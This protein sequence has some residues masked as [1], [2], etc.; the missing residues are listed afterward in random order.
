MKVYCT[1]NSDDGDSD[2][3]VNSASDGSIFTRVLRSD[4]P[5]LFR[6]DTATACLARLHDL[7]S[8]GLHVPEAAIAALTSEA[9]IEADFAEAER[10]W[11]Q[12]GRSVADPQSATRERLSRAFD[13]LLG[14]VVAV[15][16]VGTIAL[17]RYMTN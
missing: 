12:V 2:V 13:L 7:R 17:I 10:G 5:H 3:F 4:Y 14:A 16:V 11:S 1:F 9:K 8:R 6:D 15:L